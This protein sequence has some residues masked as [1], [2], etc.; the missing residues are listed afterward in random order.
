M[1]DDSDPVAIDAELTPPERTRWVYG[2]RIGRPLRPARRRL[3]TERLPDFAINPQALRAEDRAGGLTVTAG[4]LAVETVFGRPGPVL[5]EIG[6]GSGEHLLWQADQHPNWNCIGC[7][8]FL[9]GVGNLLRALDGTGTTNVRVWAND[10]TDIIT[11][12]PDGVVAMA[13]LLHPDPWP[14]ARHAKRRFLQPQR[15]GEIARRLVPGGLFRMASDDRTMIDWMRKIAAA[16]PWFQV[17]LS[18]SLDTIDRPADWPPTRYERKALEAGRMPWL[19]E[20]ER[21]ASTWTRESALSI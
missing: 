18:G 4:S 11:A 15:L 16:Q 14:K 1:T 5:L 21:I 19:F 8:P 3:L 17:T 9:T 7:E 13:F 6:F 12:L 20:L 2:R 10:A